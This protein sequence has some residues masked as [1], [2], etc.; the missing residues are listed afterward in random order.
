MQRRTEELR[1]TILGSGQQQQRREPFMEVSEEQIQAFSQ[2]GEGGI[3]PFRG[4]SRETINI[5]EKSP[6][7]SNKFGRLQEVD[8]R[9]FRDLQDVDVAISYA[10]I[11]QG[12]MLGPLF[13]SRITQVS[14]VV[15][16]YGTWEMSCPH[17][18]SEHQGSSHGAPSYQRASARLSPG[19]VFVVPPGHPYLAL[20]SKDQNLEI[21]SFKLNANGNER[22]LLAGKRNVIIQLERPAKELSFGG[23]AK[24]V[25]KIYGSQKEEYFFMGPQL[26]QQQ[27]R[28]REGEGEGEGI[29]E[30]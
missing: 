27:G 10:N 16:G 6:S 7:H 21:V 1:K 30:A 15:N 14:L 26:R 23:P 8:F 22:F 17:L 11:T 28:E 2:H 19:V 9:D 18:S 4:E 13:N 29:A 5:L 12:G 24:S 20:A 3:W 25:D